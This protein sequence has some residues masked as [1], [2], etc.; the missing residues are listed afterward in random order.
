MTNSNKSSFVQVCKKGNGLGINVRTISDLGEVLEA[1]F[2]N[3]NATISTEVMKQAMSFI[4]TENLDYTQ[5]YELS[6][7]LTTQTLAYIEN[8]KDIKSYGAMIEV[9]KDE[10]GTTR[11]K[12]TDFNSRTFGSDGIPIAGYYH[13]D[14][15]SLLKSN[16]SVNKEGFESL[17]EFA[18]FAKNAREAKL[19]QTTNEHTK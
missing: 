8:G 13:P 18:K 9:N 12:P 6:I 19:R 1:N 5:L 10:N 3:Q 4:S 2:S 17:A 15:M 7:Y 14:F 16:K 11:Y